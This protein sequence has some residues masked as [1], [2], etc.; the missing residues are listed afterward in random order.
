MGERKVDYFLKVILVG[1]MVLIAI[2]LFIYVLRLSKTKNT[3]EVCY[4]E[5]QKLGLPPVNGGCDEYHYLGIRKTD[6]GKWK[7]GDPWCYNS[8]GKCLEFC[9]GK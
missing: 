3:F 5:C 7:K 1:A 2:S 4:E 6:L 9:K 8:A